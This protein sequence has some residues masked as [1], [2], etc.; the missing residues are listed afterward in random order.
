MR[1]KWGCAT[2]TTVSLY[3]ML[4]F[5][6]IKLVRNFAEFYY[7]NLMLLESAKSKFDF[8]NLTA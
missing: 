1:L 8:C 7:N 3:F 6:Y 4:E 5:C 2:V